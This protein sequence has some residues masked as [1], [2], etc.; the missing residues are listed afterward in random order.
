MGTAWEPSASGE[1]LCGFHRTS[2]KAGLFSCRNGVQE[3]SDGH[4]PRAV[5]MTH[6]RSRCRT[7]KFL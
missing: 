6:P 2:A 1:A 5:L 4:F 3:H 7:A